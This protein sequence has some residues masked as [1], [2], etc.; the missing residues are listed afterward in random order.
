M[1]TFAKSTFSK[2][3]EAVLWSSAACNPINSDKVERAMIE[4]IHAATQ[5]LP[6]VTAQIIYDFIILALYL[7][8]LTSVAR[9]SFYS[10]IAAFAILLLIQRIFV[11]ASQAAE[12]ISAETSMKIT[13]D[14]SNTLDGLTHIHSM[15]W[16]GSI[17]KQLLVDLG[18]AQQATR[19]KLRL[20][21]WVAMAVD[22]TVVGLMTTMAISLVIFR[23]SI[24]VY[25]I[26]LCISAGC[27]LQ[28]PAVQMMELLLTL[29]NTKESLSRMEYFRSNFESEEVREAVVLPERWGEDAS[30]EFNRAVIGNH[31]PITGI[32][33]PGRSVTIR[34]RSGS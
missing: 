32:A 13:S 31:A 4:D 15:K 22:L 9:Y 29:A 18:A 5:M 12:K 11:V 16:H 28:R 19:E 33:I 1:P 17:W 30:I 27:K 24:S 23:N 14:F 26:A 8:T 3:L 34:G 20:G 7:R 21:P 2:M 10:G 25:L 6:G